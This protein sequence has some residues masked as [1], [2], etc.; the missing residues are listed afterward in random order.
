MIDEYENEDA[1]VNQAILNIQRLI[2]DDVRLNQ[3][4]KTAYEYAKKHFDK[5]QF[6]MAYREFLT[7]VP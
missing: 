7:K 6:I 2:A 4:S 3:M 5:Q 1:V